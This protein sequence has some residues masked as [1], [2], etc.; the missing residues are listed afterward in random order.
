[1]NKKGFTIIELIAVIA[2]LSIVGVL[3]TINL[4][5]TM[6]DTQAKKCTDFKEAVEEAACTYAT[7]SVEN[8]DGIK[9]PNCNN[10]KDGCTYTLKDLIEWDMIDYN[11]NECNKDIPFDRAYVKVSWDTKG[12]KVCEYYEG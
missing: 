6:K 3:V 4:T 7:L 11:E 2:I 9:I 8:A 10:R 12:E 1:M 5:K